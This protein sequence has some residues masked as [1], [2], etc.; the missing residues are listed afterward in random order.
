MLVRKARL[1]KLFPKGKAVLVALDQGMEHGPTD[2]DARNMDP[3]W[4]IKTLSRDATAFMCNEGVAEKNRKLIKCPLVLKMTGKTAL[5]PLQLQALI[6]TIDDAVKLKATAVAA[7]VYLGSRYEEEMLSQFTRIRRQAHEKQLPVMMLAYPRGPKIRNPK[8]V[9]AV[10]YGARVG[11]EMGA[12]II[13]TY[14]TGSEKSFEKVVD[15][16]VGL[17]VLMAGGGKTQPL[18][19]LKT[20]EQAMQA[21]AAGVAVGRNVWQHKQPR[22]MLAAVKAVVLKGEKPS[23][24]IK[25]VK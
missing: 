12:D 10:S 23:K 17:P 8:S 6:A 1:K 9:E 11:L 22:K 7:T 4:I 20:C 19:F 21:G 15:S 14:W 3:A 18:A 24:A 2:F 16:A 13:K 5:S 25:L